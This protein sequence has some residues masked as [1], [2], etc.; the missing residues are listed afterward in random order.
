MCINL[1]PKIVPHKSSIYSG[2]KYHQH[3]AVL[4]NYLTF[5]KNGSVYF[6]AIVFKD[7][8]LH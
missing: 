8:N 6:W 1:W 2:F 3:P 5:S 7:L 4:G